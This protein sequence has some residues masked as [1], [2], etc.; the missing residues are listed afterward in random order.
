MEAAK[1]SPE[2]GVV[3]LSSGEIRFVLLEHETD[4][5]H[6]MVLRALKERDYKLTDE[7]DISMVKSLW[8]LKERLE[9]FEDAAWDAVVPA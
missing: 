1:F 3:H 8:D 9:K 7:E 5:L 6:R 4:E 2:A